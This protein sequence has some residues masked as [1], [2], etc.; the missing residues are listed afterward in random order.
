MPSG[1]LAIW[2]TFLF[3]Y[4]SFRSSDH[5]LPSPVFSVLMMTTPKV[6]FRV[7]VDPNETLPAKSKAIASEDED[8]FEDLDLIPTRRSGRKRKLSLKLR[9]RSQSGPSKPKA[10]SSKTKKSASLPSVGKSLTF[11]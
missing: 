6:N 5:S 10:S 7:E 3:F 1:H 11:P 9:Q 2:P 4:F 8:P